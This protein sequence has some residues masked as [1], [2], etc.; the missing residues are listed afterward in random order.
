[1]SGVKSVALA[2][3]A[4]WLLAGCSALRLA[5]DNAGLYVH[6]R[7][8]S[9]LDLQGSGAEALDERIASFFE[10]HRAKELPHYARIAEEAAQRLEKGLSPADIL[11]GYDSA[12]ARARESLRAAA[13]RIAP[14][15]DQ[16]TPAQLANVERRFAD[17]NQKFAREFLRGS[18]DERRLRR[19]RRI[20]SRLEDWVGRLT[21]AQAERVREFSRRAPLYDELR[22]HDR[23]RLQA[24]LLALAR[25]RQAVRS[26]PQRAADWDGGR[27]PDYRQASEAARQQFFALL[28]DLDRSLTVE[29]RARAQ[30]NLRRYAEDFRALARRAEASGGR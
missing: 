19:A 2:L 26:L 3:A 5:Y 30:A 22:D 17:D 25:A 16:L 21:K 28:L 12:V 15:L 23:R 10:W 20:E 9:Y 7:A 6:Y 27:D 4:A 13:E 24:E 14:L 8:N 18:E 11:W 1:M 29:Q